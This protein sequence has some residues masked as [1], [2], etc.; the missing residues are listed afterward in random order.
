MEDGVIMLII[1]LSNLLCLFAIAYFS[2]QAI[3]SYNEYKIITGYTKNFNNLS[4][5]KA[6]KQDRANYYKRTMYLNI[7]ALAV[8]VLIIVSLNGGIKFG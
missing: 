1:V 2:T 5:K 7:L 3:R 4:L 8:V 6:R